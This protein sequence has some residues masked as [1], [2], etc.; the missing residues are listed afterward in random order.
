MSSGK[1]GRRPASLST[2]AE[3]A[4][5]DPASM[6]ET[7]IAEGLAPEV[8]VPPA[9][10]PRKPAVRK[11]KVV[12]A[13]V[14]VTAELEFPEPLPI[15]QESVAAVG[16]ANPAAPVAEVITAVPIAEVVS[17]ASV[18]ENAIA[19]ALEA[20]PPTA[21]APPRIR[22]KLSL[23][24][25]AATAPAAVIAVPELP[26]AVAAAEPV[27]ASVAI[28]PA[29]AAAKAP[30]TAPAAGVGENAPET[31]S[32]SVAPAIQVPPSPPP[33]SAAGLAGSV[34]HRI[35]PVALG[36][37]REVLQHLLG[38][39]SEQSTLVYTRTK[40]G[41]D[42][43]ARFLERCGLKAAA[44]H[45]DKSQ[46]AR[47]RALA[48]FKS[49]ELK[50]LVITDIAARLL[51]FEGLPMVLSYDLPHVA[52]D[53]AQRAR[54]TGTPEQVGLA[55]TIITQEESPQFRAVRD[56]MQCPL[57]L[58]PLPG[59]EAA[60]AFDPERDPPPQRGGGDGDSESAAVAEA[61]PAEARREPVANRDANAG[62]DSAA[63]RGRRDRRGR[64]GRNEN[65]P[66]D[67]ANAPVAA[68]PVVDAEA[69]EDAEQPGDRQPNSNANNSARHARPT[70]GDRPT[71][72]ERPAR[73]DR[74][75]RRERPQRG[76]RQPG[77]ETPPRAAYADDDGNDDLPGR[78][79]S[80]AAPPPAQMIAGNPGRRRGRKDPFATV[81]V[82][83]D[84]ANIYDERQPDSYRDQWSVL[85]PDTGRPAWTYADHQPPVIEAP[86][87]ARPTGASGPRRS[88][89]GGGGGAR[90][91]QPG[92][93]RGPQRHGRPRRAEGR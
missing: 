25:P 67:V 76:D 55:V 33:G 73:G 90:G 56:Y 19:V 38:Q 14:P 16:Q 59:F 50:A 83:E 72:G 87:A 28:E 82:D 64:Q 80:L 26:S 86:R 63:G 11:P 32:A 2:V 24:V 92:Q 35:H 4:H 18:A 78:G 27:A 49:G 84:R 7:G 70:N 13:P 54:R 41:A 79:N 45:G 75:G 69:A 60:E 93:P 34:T 10:K 6:V 20:E 65:R 53:Y 8:A 37:K 1:L 12:A 51:D 40:H 61:A 36:R 15:A 81:V 31:V 21:P 62:R 5:V 57:E 42:K 58:V 3:P 89:P 68:A 85:G 43:I 91:S 74:H 23:S 29:P 17:V 22:K 44:I 47:N 30:S 48:G 52:E 88:G 9:K 39:L 66:R 71:N 77:A 46:G